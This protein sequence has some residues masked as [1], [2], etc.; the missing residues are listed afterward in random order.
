[1]NNKGQNMRAPRWRKLGSKAESERTWRHHPTCPAVRSVDKASAILPVN[2]IFSELLISSSNLS[3]RPKEIFFLRPIAASHWIR[4]MGNIRG[5]L[6]PLPHD[7]NLYFLYFSSFV[8]S[9]KICSSMT[10]WSFHSCLQVPPGHASPWP[11]SFISASILASHPLPH[12]F[13]RFFKKLSQSIF[14]SLLEKK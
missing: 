7:L 5:S 12:W 4:D 8:P 3:I 11:S 9:K 14:S 10:I 1:M 2:H 6:R 13:T